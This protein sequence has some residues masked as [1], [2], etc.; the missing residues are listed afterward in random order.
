MFGHHKRKRERRRNKRE[1]EALQAEIDRLKQEQQMDPVKETQALQS[2]VNQLAQDQKERDK[3]AKEEGKVYA[4]EV[5]NR[6]Y[7]G[8][9]SKERNALQESANSQIDKDISG[10]QRKLLAQQGKRGVTGG[11]AYA[12]QA[13]LARLGVDAQQQL[14]RDITN[15]ESDLKM[16]KMAAAYNIEQGEVAQ[17]QARQQAA[18][19]I[20]NAY[21]QKKYQKWLSEQASKLF[22]K[23]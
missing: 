8:L 9:T 11:A 5:L 12:Q 18:K 3:I 19:D 13:D 20:L 15:L 17:E 21:D 22:H 16:K 7:E 2:Q 4:N 14:Q 23:V 10:Y 1:K 6:E